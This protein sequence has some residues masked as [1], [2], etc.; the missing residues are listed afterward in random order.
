VIDTSFVPVLRY[1]ALA[2][3]ALVVA[4]SSTSLVAASSQTGTPTEFYM[5]YRAA[6]EKAQKIEELVPFLAAKFRQEVEK[7]PADERVKLFGIMK[8]MGAM[9]DIKV[10]KTTKSGNGE[11][12]AVEGRSS[13]KKQT[14]SVQILNE[15]GAWK[16]GEEKCSGSF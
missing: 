11:M 9:S 6:F 1:I 7:T 5:S 3:V 4:L 10:V 16:L 12:L 13:G 15:S 2:V 14:C 8:M